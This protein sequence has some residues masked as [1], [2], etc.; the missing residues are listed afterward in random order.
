MSQD[1]LNRKY[2][3]SS[4]HDELL[5]LSRSEID[6]NFLGKQSEVDLRLSTSNPYENPAQQHS[7]KLKKSESFIK[8][9]NLPHNPA[10]PGPHPEA[11]QSSQWAPMIP[12][13][14]LQPTTENPEI[15][16]IE[17]AKLLQ[18][19]NIQDYN[20]H[21]QLFFVEQS[22]KKEISE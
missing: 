21:Q 10:E 8:W 16:R 2:F 11:F 9:S 5:D 3:A 14:Q 7:A 4:N 1:N 13:T 22:H 12:S 19:L 20:H 15:L 18:N 6:R 17:A